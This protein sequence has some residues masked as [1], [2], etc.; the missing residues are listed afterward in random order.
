[1]SRRSC[2]GAHAIKGLVPPNEFIGVAERIGLIKPLGDWV[3]ETACK[4]TAEWRA[5][6]LPNFRIAVN[7][8]PIHFQDPALLDSVAQVLEKTGLPASHL[9]LEI[10]ESVVQT[11]GEN[12]QMF[13]RLREMGVQIAIDDFGTGY[14]S[15]ASLKYLPID[16]L[17]VDRLF[18]TDMLKDPDSSIIMGTIVSVAHA[19]G[20]SVIAEGVETQEQL[21][22]LSGIDCDIVQGYFFSRPVPAELIPAL[23]KTNFQPRSSPNANPSPI[24]I[25]NEG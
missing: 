19:L 1:M 16:C 20:H 17:K 22:V 11:T 4:Q 10:T 12:M 21:K 24:K 7:I 15:L 6:G 9:E 2:A 25:V 8:S 3:L 5:Q 13:E 23:V 18:I 14:S